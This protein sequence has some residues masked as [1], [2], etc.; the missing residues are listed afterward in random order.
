MSCRSLGIEL[1]HGP[2]AESDR[3]RGM[4]LAFVRETCLGGGDAL[5]VGL[6][7]HEA[8]ACA[9]SAGPAA[10]PEPSEPPLPPG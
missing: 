2:V 1:L 4:M 5:D 10:Q 7:S 6:D 8:A 3:Q 9:R